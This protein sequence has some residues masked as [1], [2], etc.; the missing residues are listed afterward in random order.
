MGLATLTQIIASIIMMT[1]ISTAVAPSVIQQIK[2]TKVETNIIKK[3]QV[4]YE[5]VCRYIQLENSIP[6]SITDLISKGYF[7]SINNNNSFGGSFDFNI[8]STKGTMTIY[9]TIN[10]NV[11]KTTFINSYK[12]T[13]KPVDVGSNVVNS[14]FV[15]PFSIL[16]LNPQIIASSSQP[17]ASIYKFWYDTSGTQVV[18]KVS[19]G[20]TWKTVQ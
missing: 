10:D 5:A 6:S 16:Q 4:I 12:N 9:T 14:E 2:S 15:L 18:L 7:N 3:E 8:N 20:T 13:F 11:A 19:D 1:M 17:S